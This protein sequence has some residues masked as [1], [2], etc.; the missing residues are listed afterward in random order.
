MPKKDY[1]TVEE[2]N[3]FISNVFMEEDLLY[4][5]PVVGEVSGCSL[6]GGHCYFTLKDKNAQIKVAFFNIGDNYIPKNG[7]KVLVRGKVDFYGKNGTVN[8]KA[9]NIS[10]F[11]L[12]EMYKKLEIL[13]EKLEKEGLFREEEK[14]DIPD[15][16]NNICVITS[17]K[18]AAIQDFLSTIKRK[19][20]ISN[21][22]VI[23]VR[24][25]GEYAVSDIITALNNCD[26]YGFDVI[27]LCRGG[28]SFEDLYC[29]ND[30]SLVRKIFEMKTP[31]ISAIGHESDFT[32]CDYVA[33]YRCMTPTA[34]AELVGYDEKLLKNEVL[35]LLQNIQICIKS[36][37]ENCTIKLKNTANIVREKGINKY[38]YDKNMILSTLNS[39]SVL[40]NHN[41]TLKSNE[42]T[43]L[44][45]NIDNVSPMKLLNQGYFRI[46]KDNIVLN[47]VALLEQNDIIKIIG[48]DGN[49]TAKI[50]KKELKNEI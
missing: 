10:N 17:S 19:N 34:S 24:V 30:E 36:T 22:T 46:L 48:S 6:V 23:D 16:C 40:V 50:I 4:N 3:Y 47:G 9:Y 31:I 8:I 44:I 13:K 41:F 45:N 33:D 7:E 27:V 11:G 18:G 29:F 37:Y 35:T 25:Q 5:V 39:C 38:N 14:V 28:G 20:N 32:L 1:L 43:S 15:F 21:I 12:G 26:D 2:L 42:Y 49:A